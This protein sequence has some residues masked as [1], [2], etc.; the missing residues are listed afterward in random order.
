MNKVADGLKYY[1]NEYTIESM[2]IGIF[3]LSVVAGVASMGFQT[4]AKAVFAN[5]IAIAI[6]GVLAYAIVLMLPRFVFYDD[7]LEDVATFVPFFI[8]TLIYVAISIFLSKML[9]AP[10]TYEMDLFNAF[11]ILA[12][13]LIPGVVYS[14]GM[15]NKKQ[16]IWYAD[17]NGRAYGLGCR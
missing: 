7:F 5:G 13:M 16:R 10:M 3:L 17:G 1:M 6:C 2:G 9:S 14:G 12:G 8:G 15:V 11:S 4:A